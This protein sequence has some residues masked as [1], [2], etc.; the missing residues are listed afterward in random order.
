MRKAKVASSEK[1]W[2]ATLFILSSPLLAKKCS[3]YVKSRKI[4]FPE[5]MEAAGP[6][7]SSEK[8]LVKLAAALFNSSWKVD[9]NDAFWSLDIN[10]TN[11]AI[12]ALKIRFQ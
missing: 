7:S 1:D 12:E 8:A 4:L 11:L 9:I 3:K 10:N 6:W 2:H 5:L